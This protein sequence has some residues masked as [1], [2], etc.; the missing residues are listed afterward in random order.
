MEPIKQS[1]HVYP[2]ANE[3]ISKKGWEDLP[4][5]L[6][7]EIFSFLKFQPLSNLVFVCKKWK[8]LAVDNFLTKPS[9]FE[10]FFPKLQVIDEDDWKKHIDIQTHQLELKAL[11]LT[12]RVFVEIHKMIHRIEIEDSDKGF[13]LLT[14]PK[15]LS[16]AKLIKIAEQF[17]TKEGVI[18]YSNII[19]KAYDFSFKLPHIN[20][21]VLS[22]EVEQAKFII[23]PNSLLKGSRNLSVQDKFNM[24]HEAG[25]QAPKLI[26]VI[27]LNVMDYIINYQYLRPFLFYRST[28]LSPGLEIMINVRTLTEEEIPFGYDDLT[29]CLCCYNTDIAGNETI[30]IC[31]VK[32]IENVP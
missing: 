2:V 28:F 6:V 5:E 1:T 24:A 7:L 16:I 27:A 11:K 15:G 3:M 20:Q 14:I 31:P 22:T 17:K 8:A 13:T 18:A 23:L 12:R 19:G 32:V 10:K 25:C 9:C 29:K 30:G 26:D 21:E 4:K